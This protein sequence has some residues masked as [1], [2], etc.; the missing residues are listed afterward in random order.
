MMHT[1]NRVMGSVVMSVATFAAI[2]PQPAQA[3]EPEHL[4]LAEMLVA[5]VLPKAN[6]YGYPAQITWEGLNGLNY[7]TNRSK[8]ATLVTQ[9]FEKAYDVDYKSWFGCTSPIAASYHDMIED[10]DG[11]DLIKSI[12]D[13]RPGDIIAIRYYDAGCTDLTCGTF[14]NCTATG[15]VAMVADYP[16]ARAASEPFVSG[17]TQYSIEIIDTSTG[18]HGFDDTRYQS[19]VGGSNDQGIGQGTMR[20]YVNPK[21]ESSIVGH[22]WSTLS[23]SIFYGNSKRDLV[24]GRYED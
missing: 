3:G 1:W 9:L 2:C 15:H 24:I 7:S 4:D 17:T 11:F 19:D 18:Y 5:T 13:V 6:S 14:S 21:K 10:E 23:G 22:S 12:D 16:K 8:C 20:V